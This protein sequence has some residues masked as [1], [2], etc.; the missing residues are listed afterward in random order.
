[1]V[2]IRQGNHLTGTSLDHTHAG[3]KPSRFKIQPHPKYTT[4][5]IMF[6]KTEHRAFGL[7]RIEIALE[8]F[9]RNGVCSKVSRNVEEADV[10]ARWIRCQH[11][12]INNP[13]SDLASHVP[14]QVEQCVDTPFEPTITQ[15]LPSHPEL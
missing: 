10:G 7:Q 4:K 3:F 14:C 11:K 12:P 6:I 2:T 15:R 1:M 5:H 13:L 9:R 8:H